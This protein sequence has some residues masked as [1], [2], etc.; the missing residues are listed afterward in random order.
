MSTS[1]TV[2]I[3]IRGRQLLE[4][5]LSAASRPGDSEEERLRKELLLGGSV[6][7]LPVATIWGATYAF[8]GEWVAAVITLTYAAVNGIGIIYMVR[9]GRR[10]PFAEVQLGCTLVLPL[11][12]DIVLGGW[13]GSSAV[14]IG[15]L[16]APLGALLYFDKDAAV[17]WF[18]AYLL[19]V[20]ATGIAEPFLD[21]D[22]L[23]PD[24]LRTALYTMNILIVSFLAFV[25]TWSYV[26][27]RDRALNLL[28]IEQGRTYQLL[29]NILPK[30]IAD[31][32]VDQEQ[33][34]AEHFDC[35]S[36]LFADI[37]GYTPF[38]AQRDPAEL[39]GILN[40]IY[41]AFDTI[42][43]TNGVEKIRTMG[44]GYMVAAGVPVARQDHATCMARAALAMRDEIVEYNDQHDT[45]I[46]VRI[47]INSGP[48]VAGVIGRKKF[49]YDV[50]GDPVNVASRM[51]SQGVPGEI[52]V[53]FGTYDLLKDTFRFRARGPIEIKGKGSVETWLLVGPK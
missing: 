37:V 24:W 34:I 8:F 29:T 30:S 7:I 12:L 22:N 14:I 1:G 39:V 15:A 46:Q 42:I 10:R 6:A 17:N 40:D 49:S 26:Q 27:Q 45:D 48:V 9:T 47:G 4:P 18:V 13:A 36:I 35:V 43:E 11:L 31:T 50:W 3:A 32:L 33:T 51:E 28:R 5:L 23:L 41:S 25:E 19:V 2:P 52:Q 38:S 53:A 21:R 20:L 16:M 44:D